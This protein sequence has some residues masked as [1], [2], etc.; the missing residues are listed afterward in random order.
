MHYPFKRASCQAY[1]TTRT[2]NTLLEDYL[3]IEL[4][5]IYVRISAFLQ[6][7]S[8]NV[9]IFWSQWGFF[10]GPHASPDSLDM[11]DW[12]ILSY[13]VLALQAKQSVRHQ[14]CGFLSLAFWAPEPNHSHVFP[15]PGPQS[16]SRRELIYIQP[17]HS[18]NT[19]DHLSCWSY[20]SF[21]LGLLFSHPE[22]LNG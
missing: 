19:T 3:K 15:P 8:E 14:L 17:T 20:H 12:F 7:L 6:P 22:S 9:Y 21:V 10:R 16:S 4:R 13:P 1:P 5:L 2:H 11:I 18:V